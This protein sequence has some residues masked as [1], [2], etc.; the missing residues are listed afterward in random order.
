MDDVSLDELLDY[1]QPPSQKPYPLTLSS[2][3]QL[4]NLRLHMFACQ[5]RQWL[6]S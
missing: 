4:L 1:K 3:C 6:G 5:E 2:A